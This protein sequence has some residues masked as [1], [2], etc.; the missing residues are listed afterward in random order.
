M[1]IDVKTVSGTVD[2]G[3]G[4]EVLGTEGDA[5][6]GR[7]PADCFPLGVRGTNQMGVCGG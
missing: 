2:A 6:V 4:V 5:K 3:T 7:S 1:K